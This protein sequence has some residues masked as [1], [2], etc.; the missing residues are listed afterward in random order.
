MTNYSLSYLESIIASRRF[1]A[2]TVAEITDEIL[3][4]LSDDPTADVEEVAESMVGNHYAINHATRS[5][6]LLLGSPYDSSDR[7]NASDSLS[8]ASA[9]DHVLVEVTA[10]LEASEVQL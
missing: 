5:R 6:V 8:L 9:F 1:F 4:H 10:A 3:G 7:D 2:D